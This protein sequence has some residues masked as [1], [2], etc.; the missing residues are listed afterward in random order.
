MT[1]HSLGV[2]CGNLPYVRMRRYGRAGCRSCHDTYD[3]VAAADWKHRRVARRYPRD[4]GVGHRHYHVKGVTFV[5]EEGR[6]AD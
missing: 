2:R 3:R 1:V 6:D 5:G 4:C